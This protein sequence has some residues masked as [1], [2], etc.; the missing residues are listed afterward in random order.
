MSWAEA[1]DMDIPDFNYVYAR[2]EE[3]NN[4][5][6]EIAEKAGQRQ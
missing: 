1:W 4:K 5:N 3:I 6:A 2:C